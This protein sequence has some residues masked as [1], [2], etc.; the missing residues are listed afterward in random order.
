MDHYGL[1]PPAP[2]LVKRRNDYLLPML[3]RGCPD[4]VA[5]A[6]AA[7][8]CTLSTAITGEDL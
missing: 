4:I 6:G 2:P 3:R 1:R 7:I 8:S 5:D